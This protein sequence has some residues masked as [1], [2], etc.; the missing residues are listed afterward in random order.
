MPD[1]IKRLHYYDQQF[2]R[3]PDFTDEQKYHMDMRRRL[4]RVLHGWGIVEGL[5]TVKKSNSTATIQPGMALDADGREIIV[6]QD[7]DVLIPGVPGNANKTYYVT[8]KYKSPEDLTDPPP[9]QY[10]IDPSD[11]TRVTERPE[12]PLPSLATPADRTLVLGTVVLD[13][14]GNILSINENARQYAPK[15]IDGKLGVGTLNP[16]YRLHVTASGGFGNEN[17]DGTSQAGS[18]PLVVQS[19]S[20]VF[21]ALN[22]HG[23]QAFALNIEGNGA[24]SAARGTPVFYDKYDGTWHRSIYLKN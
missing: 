13:G 14:S 22:S 8:I 17:A 12:I 18:V 10:M 9:P 7:Q 24:T 15:G 2:L 6:T 23:R 16:L 19:D 20:T 5:K 1:E 4:N 3:E 21:G 11:R